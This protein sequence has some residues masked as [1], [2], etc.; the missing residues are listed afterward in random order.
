MQEILPSEEIKA[1]DEWNVVLHSLMLAPSPEARA[2]GTMGGVDTEHE[3]IYIYA[4]KIHY[5]LR[6]Y[7]DAS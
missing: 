6:I 3:S 2:E 5:E 1:K 7:Y 4:H